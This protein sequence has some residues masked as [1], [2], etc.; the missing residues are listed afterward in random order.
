MQMGFPGKVFNHLYLP[1]A[2]IMAAAFLVING[3]SVWLEAAYLFLGFLFGWFLI[4]AYPKLV[5]SPQV[6]LILSS[7]VFR[8]GFLLFSFWLAVS[9]ESLIALGVVLG[10]NIFF[11][12]ELVF[13][14]QKRRTL[15]K[16]KLFNNLEISDRLLLTYVI[17]F[18][19]LVAFLTTL[20]IF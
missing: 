17:G 6:A 11:I 13:D 3:W 4:S 14:Y 8:A 5:K 1:A 12:R 7:G 15:L 2:A 16:K 10:A 19:L 9:N 20:V 18:V